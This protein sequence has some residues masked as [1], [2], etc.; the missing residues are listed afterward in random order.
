MSLGNA[1]VVRSTVPDQTEVRGVWTGGG[2]ATDCSRATGDANKGIISF[3]YNAATGKYRVT[4]TDVGQQ[5]LDATC[6]VSRVSGSIPLSANVIRG[7][8]NVANKTVD[9]EFWSVAAGAHTLT[10]LAATDKVLVTIV[11]TKNQPN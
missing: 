10:D 7:S 9:I 8:L 5:I 6:N 4:L 1:S 11:F 3:K 2:A